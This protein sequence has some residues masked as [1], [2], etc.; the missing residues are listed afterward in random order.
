VLVVHRRSGRPRDGL[1][2]G[3]WDPVYEK[4]TFGRRGC[5]YILSVNILR[6][7]LFTCVLGSSLVACA[8]HTTVVSAAPV[9]S[10]ITV[11]GSGKATG[12][13][14][15]ATIQVGVHARAKDAASATTAV[16][17]ASQ[18]IV[19]ALRAQGLAD[20]DMQ[21]RD[22]S[23]YEEREMPPMP[24]PTPDGQAQAPQPIVNY[25]ARNTLALTVRKLEQLPNVL[26]AAHAAGA[27]EVYGVQ[28]KID[29]P[30]PFEAEARADA[31]ADAAAKAKQLAELGGRRLGRLVAVEVVEGGG[32]TPR[33]YA[34]AAMEAGRAMDKSTAAVEAG[35]IEIW[36]RVLVHYELE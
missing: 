26:A 1:V 14:D 35:E 27:N 17:D 31:F 11:S 36:Q 20:K 23:V 7:T 9:Q 12:V 29:D 13:P 32:N 2:I 4:I 34:L 10:G 6:T 3:A 5:A 15:V 19:A 18:K 33:P 22:L 24:V 25:V 28:L 30:S 21:T 8:P 16:N